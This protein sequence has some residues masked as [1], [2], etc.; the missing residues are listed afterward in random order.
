MLAVAGL[1]WS[2]SLKRVLRKYAA[3]IEATSGENL[4]IHAR[5]VQSSGPDLRLKIKLPNNKKQSTTA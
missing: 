2:G 1:R 3:R 4:V 5:V